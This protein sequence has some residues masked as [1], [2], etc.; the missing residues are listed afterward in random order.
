MVQLAP[1]S[2]PAK[3]VFTL[4]PNRH[5]SVKA[6]A[7]LNKMGENIIIP[8]FFAN[9][10]EGNRVESVS[11]LLKQLTYMREKE[12]EVSDLLFNVHKK[13]RLEEVE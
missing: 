2:H 8:C 12:K 11:R 3:K 1:N 4:L 9:L 5:T 10:S 13:L 6:A 7:C